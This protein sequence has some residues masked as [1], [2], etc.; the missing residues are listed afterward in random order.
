MKMLVK[1]HAKIKL[2]LIFRLEL[3]KQ[4]VILKSSK[5]DEK[6]YDGEDFYGKLI[7]YSGGFPIYQID[8]NLKSKSK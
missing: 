1:Y 8:T 4:K 5:E 7:F 6:K 2:S 3:S